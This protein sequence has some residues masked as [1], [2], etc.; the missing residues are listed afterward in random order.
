MQRRT[1][2]LNCRRSIL[3]LF[4]AILLATGVAQVRAQVAD[5]PNEDA[6]MIL[7]R[8]VASVDDEIILL[9]ELLAEVQI[10]IMR[11]GKQPSRDDII[12]LLDE[13]LQ[14]SIR[15][16]L[17]IAKARREE[18]QIGDDELERAMDQHIARLQEQAGSEARFQRELDREGL[19]L[20]DLR[21][22][23]SDPM[24]NQILVQQ[25]L[26]RLTY[27]VE[28]GEDE[29]RRFFDENRN[30]AEIIPMRPQML[31]LA[32]ILVTPNPDPQRSEAVQA[33]LE[34][35]RQRL[36]AGDDF[37]SVATE[38]S[39]GPAATR[40]GDMG[41]FRLSDIAI[42]AIAQALVN[43]PAGEI[44]D[45]VVSEQGLH[46]LKMEERQ[47]SQVHFSQIFFALP[48]G[49]EDKQRARELAREA[50]K[51]LQ[52]GDEWDII[53]AE[54]SNDSVTSADGGRLP[55][56]GQDQLDERYKSV[57]EVLEPGEYSSV[58]L[59]A[60][61][62]EI[63][64]L[65]ERQKGRSFEYEE[66]SQQLQGELLGRKRTEILEGYVKELE[67]EIV[68]VRNG[69]PPIEEIAGLWERP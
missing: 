32:H 57:I 55:L 13:A 5:A 58:F 63:V 15:E 34:Q 25:I 33:R 6:A 9:S 50:W 20:R 67:E 4:V 46:L 7:E 1:R 16:K 36:A 26:E 35:V 23:L 27:G 40:G 12:S 2:S 24:R 19:S 43:L 59:A 54:Y 38:F 60:Q 49:E 47:G 44:G 51:R 62:Y 10:Y 56:I 39:D 68:I 45:L 8:V 28:V 42:P 64:R 31:A 37:A 22:K 66:I 41:T 65:V 21:K 30:N 14:N 53:A 11:T 61:G 48:L 18:I 17:L 69:I 3:S 52:A 29:A